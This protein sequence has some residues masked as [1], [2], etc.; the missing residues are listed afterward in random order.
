MR[1]WGRAL[2]FPPRKCSSSGS[3]EPVSA[4]NCI[5]SDSTLKIIKNQTHYYHEDRSH[6]YFTKTHTNSILIQFIHFFHPIERSNQTHSC[7]ETSWRWYF[8]QNPWNSQDTQ[9]SSNSVFQFLNISNSVLIQFFNFT[10]SI[11]IQFFTLF[12][13]IDNIKNYKI[14]KVEEREDR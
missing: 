4:C 10:N 1:I 7:Q 8:N 11:L 14:P 3:I 5:I 13:S 2:T 12:H 6:W 9:L